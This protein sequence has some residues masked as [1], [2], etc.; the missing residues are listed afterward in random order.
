MHS[1]STLTSTP[2]CHPIARGAAFSQA[3]TKT[4]QQ[5]RIVRC[6]KIAV[7]V[8]AGATALISGAIFTSCS[9]GGGGSSVVAGGNFVVLQTEPANNGRLFLN[10]PIALDFSNS[11]DLSTAN[12]NTIAFSVFDT[13]GN[14]LSEQ[15]VGNFRLAR[16]PGDTEIGRRL[17]FVP[18]FP[19]NNTY[20]DGGFRPGRTYI[21]Q[22]VGGSRRNGNVLKDIGGKG[23]LVP[24]SFQF[25]TATGTTPSQLFRDTLAGGPRRVSFS[26]TPSNTDPGD[27]GTS[28]SKPGQAL[29]QV[30]LQFNQP[31]N[32]HTDNVPVMLSPNPLTRTKNQRGRIF[33]EY[34]DPDPT[35]GGDTWIPAEVALVDNTLTGSEV[36]LFPIGVLPNNATIRVIVENTLEDMSGQS[37]VE[38]VSYN[39]E[40]ASFDTK[41]ALEP[42]F[43]AVVEGF[44]GASKLIDLE[45]PFLEPLAHQENGYVRAALNFEGSSTILDYEPNTLDVILNTNFTQI[46]PKGAPPFNVAGGVFQFRNVRIPDGVTVRGTGTNPMIWQVTGDFVVD[47]TLQVDGG[48]G[49]RVNVLASANFA[50]GGGVGNCDGGSGGRGSPNTSA[51][52]ARG[53]RGFGPGQVPNRGGDGG[54]ISTNR[55][56][57]RGSGGGGGSFATKGDPNFGAKAGSS[58][59]FPQQLG[60]GGFGCTGP[61]GSIN[62]ALP[63]GVAGPLA[64]RDAR[65]DNNF[66]GSGVDI[67]RLIRIT[68]ELESPQGGAGGGGGG[69]RANSAG[70]AN[71]ISNNKG[72][73]GGAGG[74]VLIIEAL[75]TIRIG[76]NGLISANGG[77][78]GGGEQAGGNNQGGG[79][80]GG[81]GGMV[82]LI[83]GNRIEITKHGETYGGQPTA[84]P[85][86]PP[87][88]NFAVSADGSVGTQGRFGGLEWL[89]K[90]P[91]PNLGAQWDQNPAGG[92]GGMGLVQLMAPAGENADNTNT[93]LDDN[94]ILLDSSGVE[95]TDP[96]ERIRYIGWRGFLN[97]QGQWVDDDNMPTYANNP[98]TVDEEGD[99]R[100]APILLPGTISPRSHMRSQWIDTGR[101]TR[102]PLSQF[103]LASRTIRENTAAKL[104]AGPTYSFGGTN[105]EQNM[106]SPRYK[107]RGYLDYSQTVS[108][109]ALLAPAVLAAPATISSVVGTS[110]F[111]GQPAYQVKLAQPVL[112][113][114][115][116]RYSQYQAQ[117][118][119]TAA[120]VVAEYRIVGHDN[121]FLYLS[122]DQGPLPTNLSN[123]TLQVVAKFIDVRTNGAPGLGRTYT[124]TIGQTTTNVP[125]ANIQI[126]FA[127]HKNPGPGSPTKG[128]DPNRL[129]AE[130][131]TFLY[132]LAD[133]G[134]REVVRTF[135]G[136]EV[137]PSTG[138][139]TGNP[140]LNQESGAP[141]IMWDMLFNVRF[142]EDEPNNTAA[143]STLSPSSPLPEVHTLV[144][145]YRF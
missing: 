118:I 116:D 60:G 23:L 66:W 108:G 124:K 97:A 3:A 78:G 120:A 38:D 113:V 18:R 70:N 129:P 4:A 62:R 5:S 40:F 19:T 13:A 43:D 91:P 74:G 79:G 94:I 123:L 98:A 41:Q 27:P 32:P 52:S 48:P 67:Q 121:Q 49:D 30:V 47:G 55:N 135:T 26:V 89:T 2:P 69:D 28:L 10:D 143:Q 33:L 142:S 101:S 144:I 95:I 92:F 85:A 127:F 133:P 21:V 117:F 36:R 12:L 137:N 24:R 138:M 57:N 88:Y 106:S 141:F 45:A 84:T 111:E 58:N 132:D 71:F 107:W 90:Y 93:R 63:G 86:V 20:T 37:N 131:G 31:L 80:A 42:Q 11:V 75:D 110:S 8:L 83:A 64:F 100:P 39:R 139:L 53:E 76:P 25:V 104:L 15:P 109:V 6:S 56:C 81:S 35:I 17:E 99:I 68:G 112:G 145:P 134:V 125:V 115:S 22:L 73:G 1:P 46:T 61:S 54:R 96:A 9:S 102:R 50:T 82:V 136:W 77:T 72:G 105:A 14:P 87:D 130:V 140:N 119:N 34:D 7:G 29:V 126:G 103:G 59:S 16:S 51:Q 128:D 114:I 44:D 65:Q 122:P